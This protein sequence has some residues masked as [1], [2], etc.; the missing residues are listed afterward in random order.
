MLYGTGAIKLTEDNEV[1]R[2]GGVQYTIKD[3]II[4]DAKRMLADVKKRLLEL[5]REGMTFAVIEHNM[6]FIFEVAHRILVIA[7]GQVLMVGTADE[8]RNDPKVI[9][10]YLGH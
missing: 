10:A 4:Y 8:V 7:E 5:N 6:E 2:A 9:E 3:G 1:I